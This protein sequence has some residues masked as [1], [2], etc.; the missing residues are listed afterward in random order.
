M[1]LNDGDIVF[2]R[3]N[4]FLPM[5]KIKKQWLWIISGALFGI[6]VVAYCP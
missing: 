2:K 6:V 5:V 4:L 3:I 1:H